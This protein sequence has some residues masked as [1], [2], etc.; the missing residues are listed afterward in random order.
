MTDEREFDIVLYGASG[1]VGHLTAAR[2]AA[3]HG[4]ARIALAAIRRGSPRKEA[5]LLFDEFLV[6]QKPRVAEVTEFHECFG[7]LVNVGGYCLPVSG[8]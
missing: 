4:G 3:G 8:R 6:S 7:E 1:F 2:L 5:I